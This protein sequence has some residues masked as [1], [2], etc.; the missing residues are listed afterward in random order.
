[1]ASPC[2]ST[3]LSLMGFLEETQQEWADGGVA[4]LAPGAPKVH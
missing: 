4:A 3:V 1:M 2:P